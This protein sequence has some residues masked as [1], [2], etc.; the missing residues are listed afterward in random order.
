[1]SYPK[2][3]L[4]RGVWSAEDNCV[5]VP[6]NAEEKAANKNTVVSPTHYYAVRTCATNILYTRANSIVNK[7]CLADGN[8]SVTVTKG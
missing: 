2:N 1:G 4:T 5:K 7:N 3:N 8:L 6:A